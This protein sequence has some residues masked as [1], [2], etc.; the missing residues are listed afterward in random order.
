MLKNYLKHSGLC[1]GLII[2]PYHWE[3]IRFNI[4]GPT[5]LDPSMHTFFISLGP[6]WIR[7]VVDNGDW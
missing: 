5:E 2:N 1:I 6:I 3:K 4:T 7:G